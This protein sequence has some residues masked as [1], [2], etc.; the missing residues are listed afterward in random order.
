[1]SIYKGTELE[2]GSA[3]SVGFLDI[4]NLRIMGNNVKAI[5]S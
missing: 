1:M 2:S 4:S 3:Q 5:L